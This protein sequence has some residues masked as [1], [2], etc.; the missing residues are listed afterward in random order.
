M[1]TLNWNIKLLGNLTPRDFTVWKDAAK[2]PECYNFTITDSASGWGEYPGEKETSLPIPEEE[3]TVI[4]TGK[5]TYNLFEPYCFAGHKCVMNTEASDY[6]TGTKILSTI[7]A[8]DGLLDKDVIET[9]ASKV[10]MTTWIKKNYPEAVPCCD[11]M[12]SCI[13]PATGYLNDTDNAVKLENA[14]CKYVLNSLGICKTGSGGSVI[15]TETPP[16]G[17]PAIYYALGAG[18]V[19]AIGLI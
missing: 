11:D 2:I 13:D 16:Q 19:G 4:I 14:I 5:D 12:E 8:S 6:R 15:P 10:D 9:I 1:A 3:N 7:M 18:A 17:T